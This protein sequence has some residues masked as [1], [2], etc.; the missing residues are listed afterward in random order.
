MLS[1]GAKSL[2]AKGFGVGLY[3]D[4]RAE[5]VADD[6]HHLY[7]REWLRLSNLMA[8][9][10]YGLT[11]GSV[12]MVSVAIEVALP[13]EETSAAVSPEWQDLLDMATDDERPLLI[14]LGAIVGLP[15]PELGFELP[16]GSVISIAWPDQKVGV[17]LDGEDPEVLL[18]AGWTAVAPDAAEVANSLSV[19]EGK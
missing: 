3:L 6:D 2:D 5:A 10:R 1:A 18:G 14:E 13:P 19:M 16:D 11:I 7:W 12:D 8:F 17:L 15:V 9:K 4:D